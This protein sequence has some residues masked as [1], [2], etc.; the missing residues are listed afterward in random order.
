MLSG[1]LEFGHDEIT[2]RM[3]KICAYS[4]YIPLQMIY[5]P[6]LHRGTFPQQ[7]KKANVV[8]VHKKSDKQFM[9]NY[10]P[11]TCYYM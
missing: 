4:V 7:W 6:C 9:K 11:T 5:K 10:R 3:L 2:I 1:D 8:S